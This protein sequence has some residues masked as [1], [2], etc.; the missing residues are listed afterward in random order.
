MRCPTCD[1]DLNFTDALV[2]IER[3]RARLV[4]HP[5]GTVE[6]HSDSVDSFAFCAQ[7]GTPVEFTDVDFMG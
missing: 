1:S 5:E 2:Y 7:C 3:Y 4:T 6:P